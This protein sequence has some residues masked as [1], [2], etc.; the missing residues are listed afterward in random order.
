MCVVSAVSDN[1]RDRWPSPIMP[2]VPSIIPMV[3]SEDRVKPFTPEDFDKIWDKL[4]QKPTRV[5]TEAEWQEYQRLKRNAMEIDVLTGQPDCVKP[6]VDEWENDIEAFLILM[7]W[8]T[9]EDDI[10][11]NADYLLG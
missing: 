11:D 10:N 5:I 8:M 9:D 7:G 3:P 6:D 2:Y 4:T 1:M